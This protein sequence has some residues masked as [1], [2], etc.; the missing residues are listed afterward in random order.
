MRLNSCACGRFWRLEAVV[1]SAVARRARPSSLFLRPVR[2]PPGFGERS[3][4]SLVLAA[5]DPDYVV[6]QAVT[7]HPGRSDQFGWLNGEGRGGA[8]IW[9]GSLAF[10]I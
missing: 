2:P 1:L 10:Q 6:T 8:A 9:S 7:V 4:R 5:V 3:T